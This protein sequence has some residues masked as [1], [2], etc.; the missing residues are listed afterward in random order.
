MNTPSKVAPEAPNESRAVTAAVMP[1]PRPFYWS[2]RCELWENRS[3]YI[4][5]LIVA[6]V[7]IFGFAISTIGL[8]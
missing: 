7:Q 6:V 2:V 1:P 3:I 4:A 8:A 5:P